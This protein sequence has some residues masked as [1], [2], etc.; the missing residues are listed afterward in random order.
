MVEAAYINHYLAS[1]LAPVY[2][3]YFKVANART[4]TYG[5]D[6]GYWNTN[7]GNTCAVYYRGRFQ[8][9]THFLHQAY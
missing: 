3:T 9:A 4:S 8:L 5:N 1:L 7:I 6:V 2:H